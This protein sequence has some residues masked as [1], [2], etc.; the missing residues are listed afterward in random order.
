MSA[1]IFGFLFLCNGEG[2]VRDFERLHIFL[3]NLCSG[4]TLI[5]IYTE[6]SSRITGKGAAFLL[7][8]I[9]YALFAYLEFYI[10]AIALSVFLSLLV[11]TV[12]IRKFSFLPVEFFSRDVPVARKF[13]HASLLCLSLALFISALVILNNEYLKFVTMKKLQLN[14]FFLGFSFPISLIT[15]SVMFTFLKEHIDPFLILLKHIGFW[16]VNAG[17]VI[18]FVFILF[19]VFVLQLVV[20]II[21]FLSVV[22]LFYVFIRAGVKSQEKVFL[23][24]GMG[25]LVFTAITGIVYIIGEL[26]VSLDLFSY[27]KFFFLLLLKIHAFSALYGWNLS[28]LSVIIRFNDFPIKLNMLRFVLLHW[29]LVIVLAP[30]GW[31][32]PLFALTTIM[33]FA[34]ILYIVFFSSGSWSELLSDFEIE[35]KS[36]DRGKGKLKDT[37]KLQ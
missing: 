23:T 2:T 3:F 4:G 22:M 12:R 13:H 32:Y 20:T 9:V 29:C 28:G 11:E 19:E 5:I 25:F 31:F 37:F 21:L 14:T 26:L 8:S 33:V 24:S 27:N 1:L 15:M 35:Y 34:Y 10:P 7:L 30:L 18:F 36:D 17:V 6:K 16:I